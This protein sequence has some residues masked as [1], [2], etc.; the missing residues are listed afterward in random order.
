MN[1][2]NLIKICQVKEEDSILI[3]NWRNNKE[4]R[5]MSRN[6]NKI[7]LK[8]HKLWLIKSLLNKE[9]KMYL[10]KEKESPVGIIIFTKM[11]E[12]RYEISMNL[13][14]DFRGKGYGE[15][16]LKKGINKF[17]EDS[18]SEYKLIAVIKKVNKKS[19]KLFIKMMFELE[20]NDDNFL[21]YSLYSK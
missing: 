3:W 13:N 19:Q 14:P 4:T 16:V 15:K 9:N 6:K 20:K 18:C 10:C 7:R 12:N 2:N 1:Q 8:D 11:T 21:Y 5:M 17:K